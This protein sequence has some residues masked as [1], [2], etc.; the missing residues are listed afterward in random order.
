MPIRH[1]LFEPVRITLDR[2]LAQLRSDAVKVV[3]GGAARVWNLEEVSN[4]ELNEV[5]VRRFD[6]RDGR[7][8]ISRE[9]K[10]VLAALGANAEMG[11]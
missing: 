8:R 6:R 7:E 1:R 2:R 11:S 5:P 10:N 9:Q 4:V 3:A